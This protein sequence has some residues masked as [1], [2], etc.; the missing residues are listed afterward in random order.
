MQSDLAH[1]HGVKTVSP[2]VVNKAG[3]VAVLNV[4]PTTRPQATAT[5]NLV[6][7]LRNTVLPKEHLTTYVTG[8]TAGT[9]DFTDRI[10]ARLVWLIVAV[11]A[12]SFLLLTMAFRSIVIATKAAILNLLSIGAAVGVIVA[13]FQYGWGASLIGVHTALPIPA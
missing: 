8:T 11:I 6:K 1:T 10:T 4:I 7:T 12:I 2:P 5:T 13:I 9:V 3:T